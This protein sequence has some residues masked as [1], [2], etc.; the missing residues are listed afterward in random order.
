MPVIQRL[1]GSLVLKV[2]EKTLH[3]QHVMAGQPL[4]Y[5]T[6]LISA[7]LNLLRHSVGAVDHMDR[8]ITNPYL[9][10]WNEIAKKLLLG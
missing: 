8:Y 9:L 4:L 10:I 6:E 1:N 2:F 5:L 7:E 3:S